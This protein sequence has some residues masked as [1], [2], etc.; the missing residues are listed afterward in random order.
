M[1]LGPILTSLHTAIPLLVAGLACSN[2]ARL[3]ASNTAA[4]GDSGTGGTTSDTTAA[5]GGGS[6][7]AGAGGTAADAGLDAEGTPADLLVDDFEDGDG[8]SL[9]PGNWYGYDDGSNGGKSELAFSGATGS[10]VVMNGAGYDSAKSLAVSYTFDQGTYEYAPYVGLGVSIGSAAVPYDLGRYAGLSYTYKGGAHRIRVETSEVLDYDNFG[11]DVPASSSWTTVTLQ[12]GSFA[13]EGWG[14]KVAFDPSHT[15]ALSFGIKGTTGEAGTLQIDDLKVVGAIS[16]G[17]P[18][19]RIEPVTP[20]VDGTLASVEITN[21]LQAKAA[22][23]LSRGANITNWLEQDRFAGFTYDETYVAKLAQAGFRAL[24]LPIDLDL[25]VTSSVGTGATLAITVSND[26]FTI[27]DNFNSWTK[28]HGLSL[29]IDYHQ[30]S[31]LLDLSRPDSVST[32]VKL[33]G[34][35][36]EHFANEPREDL[37]FELLNEPELSF[38]GTP[39]TQQQWTT[40]AEQMVAAIR[41]TNTTHSIIFGDVQWYS[42]E[43]LSSRNPLSDA[44]IVYA[45]HDYDPFIFTH[46]GAGWAKLGSVHDL[47]YPYSADRWSQYY[48]DLGFN[49]MMDS[50]LLDQAQNYYTAGTRSAVRNHILAAKRWAVKNNVPV[51]CNEFGAYDA[52]SR[53]EDRVRYYTDVVGVFDELAIPW[54][55]W[56]MVMDSS[57]GSVVPEYRSAMKLGH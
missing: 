7:Q 52:S 53:L 5:S 26:L 18:D 49:S 14:S 57:T 55:I 22:R 28:T 16:H 4:G 32:A 1:K 51:I 23:Y 30:Y 34:M 35:I 3:E 11:V 9:I 2:T 21:P 48:S 42:I 6:S 15:L 36:A 20:P 29:T 17:T 37:F 19:M 40:I 10:A 45:F 31:T 41:A 27:L 8:K 46:Q 44:N 50:W 43:A 24:R 13:Q 25:Y 12:F 54:Q 39:P 38:T 56:F 33:W 47:P